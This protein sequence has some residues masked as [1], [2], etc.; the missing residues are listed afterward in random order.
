VTGPLQAFG[1]ELQKVRK[2]YQALICMNNEE[3]PNLPPFAAGQALTQDEM[4]DILL[5]GTPHLWQNEMKCQ[6]FDP[7]ASTGANEVIDFMENIKAVEEKEQSFKKVKS[8]NK[9]I[10][11]KSDLSPPKKKKF[12]CSYHGANN[13]HDTKDCL[14]IKNKGGDKSSGNKK[15]PN[16]TQCTKPN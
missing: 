13:S 15:S 5:H 10:K 16:T 8:K 9:E 11:K 6:G 4:I 14:V 12:Y 3:L 7:M 2:Y 1:H